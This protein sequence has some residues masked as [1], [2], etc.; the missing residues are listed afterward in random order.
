MP[1]TLSSSVKVFYPKHNREEII[2]FIKDA[3]PKLQEQ[4]SLKLVVL[5]G[6][7]AKGNYTVASDIDLLI[8]YSGSNRDDA[9]ALCK[10]TLGIPRLEPHVYSVKEYQESKRTVG[11]MIKDSIILIGSSSV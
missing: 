7:Y 6:S 5:F 1:R 3:L 10:R 4:L 8:V 2:Q 11:H 9:F